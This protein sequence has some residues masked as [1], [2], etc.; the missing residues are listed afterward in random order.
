[1]LPIHLNKKVQEEETG[2][3]SAYTHTCISLRQ[4]LVPCLEVILL[5]QGARL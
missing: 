1:M 5:N 4:G 2:K 3:I